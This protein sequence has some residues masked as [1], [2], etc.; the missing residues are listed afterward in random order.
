MAQ[1][2][3]CSRC[4]CRFPRFRKASSLDASRRAP[5]WPAGTTTW[6]APS[7]CRTHDQT[8]WFVVL[9]FQIRWLVVFYV[10]STP[11]S[12]RDN[13]P[14]YCPL[15]RTWSLV[16]TPCWPVWQTVNMYAIGFK[17][18]FCES[19]HLQPIENRLMYDAYI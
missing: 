18:I 19:A 13:T 9:F 10:L 15:R 12:F 1:D 3:I 8:L 11:R 4:T 17:Y 16:F 14:I 2:G 6:R 5:S 7:A